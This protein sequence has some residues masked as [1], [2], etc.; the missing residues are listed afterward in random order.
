MI[1]EAPLVWT[2]MEVMLRAASKGATHQPN[3]Q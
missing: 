2:W 3:T 1:A